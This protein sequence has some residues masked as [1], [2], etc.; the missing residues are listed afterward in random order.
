MNAYFALFVGGLIA[1]FAKPYF[2][3]YSKTKGKHLAEKE[4]VAL[5]TRLVEDVKQQNALALEGL[6]GENLLRLAAAERRLQAHQ[7]GFVHWRAMLKLLYEGDL[8]SAVVEAQTW[9]ERNCLFLTPGA[10]DAFNLAYFAARSVRLNSRQTGAHEAEEMWL[11]KF[12]AAA[13]ELVEGV[14]LPSLGSREQDMVVPIQSG[15]TSAGVNS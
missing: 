9:W 5:L 6:K 8:G 10:R 1:W 4:D 14:S 2:S 7:E 15:G 12:M 3:E 13:D 11:K